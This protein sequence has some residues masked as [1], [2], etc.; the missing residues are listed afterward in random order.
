M[1]NHTWQK[2]AAA[3]SIVV[4]IVKKIGDETDVVREHVI[5]S[6]SPRAYHNVQS[7]LVR[8]TFVL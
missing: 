2:S 4:E 8:K 5:E 1:L 7:D 6:T 3:T